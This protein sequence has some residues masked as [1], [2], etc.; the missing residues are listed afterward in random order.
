[1]RLPATVQGLLCFTLGL[2]VSPV[3]WFNAFEQAVGRPGRAEHRVFPPFAQSLRLPGGGAADGGGGARPPGAQRR[4]PNPALPPRHPEFRLALVVPWLGSSFPPWFPYFVLSC[5]R[6]AFMV[7]WLIFH[8]DADWADAAPYLPPNV[9]MH[10]LG[11][12]GLAHTFGTSLARVLNMSAQTA[13]L[14]RAF[15]YSFKQYTYI[16]TEYKPTLGAVFAPFL[17]RYTHWSY[18]DLDTVAGDLPRFLE[19]DELTNFDIVTYSFGDHGRLYLRGQFAMHANRPD[20]NLQFA[21][22]DHLGAGLLRELAYKAERHRKMSEDA[23]RKGKP[24]PRV[25]FI[26]AEGCY[27]AAIYATPGIR[28]KIANKFFADFG[29]KDELAVV[30]GSVRRCPAGSAARGER[31]QPCALGAEA[32]ADDDEAGARD[33][34][35]SLELAGAYDVAGPLVPVGQHGDCSHW[36]SEQ[37]RVCANLSKGDGSNDDLL[38]LGGALYRRKRRL[39]VRDRRYDS[40]AFFH[41][42]TW[43]GAYKAL[44]LGKSDALPRP[45]GSAFA[46]SSEGMSPKPEWAPRSSPEEDAA[47]ARERAARPPFVGVEVR[48]TLLTGGE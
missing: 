28:V 21:R 31:R 12:S 18:T 26:S 33:R 17:E 2:V 27:S 13:T 4:A 44:Q 35:H 3:L 11:P 7:D 20:L 39:R 41:F 14:V 32:D 19:R 29:H 42:Q 5:G 16:V 25:R 38:F 23:A 43:K 40:G 6:S 30:G 8:E 15:E 46:C 9:L 47:R 36:V 22:C 34:A 10:N 45:N 37:W 24:P 1:M 48:P